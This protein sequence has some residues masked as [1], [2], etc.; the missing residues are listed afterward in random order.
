M[1]FGSHKMVKEIVIL[2]NSTSLPVKFII[3]LSLSP[4][5]TPFI[6]GMMCSFFSTMLSP[7]IFLCHLQNSDG[8]VC[9]SGTGWINSH[10]LQL[11]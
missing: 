1:D 7:D 5:S 9:R 11:N 8:A 10:A 2:S 3:S 4:L 6:Y